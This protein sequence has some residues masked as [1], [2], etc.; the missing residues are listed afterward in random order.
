MGK[1][2]YQILGVDK[3][4]TQDEIKKAFRK[5]AHQHHPDKGG[6][7]AKF[8]EINEAYQVLN[9][10]KKR[11]QYDQF[12]TTFDGAGQQYSNMNWDDF[13]GQFGDIF[14]GFGFGGGQGQSRVHVDMGDIF[15]QAFGGGQSHARTRRDTR[16]HDMELRMDIDFKEAVFGTEKTI[17]LNIKETCQQCNGKGA[18]PDS[19]MITC[20]E[21][22]GSGQTVHTQRT[23]LGTFQQS[24]I[25]PTCHGE[26]TKPEQF[27]KKCH[28]DGRAEEKKTITIKVPAGIDH[29]QTIKLTG[30][31]EAGRRGGGAGDLYI[32][33]A[34]EN[35]TQFERDGYTI[36]T[37][38]VIPY[39]TAALGGTVRVETLDGKVDLKIPSGTQ[40]A[41]EFKLKNKGIPNLG[42]EHKRGDHYVHIAI[43]VPKKL[44]RKQK[45]LL[46]ELAEDNE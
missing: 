43:E 40:V 23:I 4:S 37:T 11:Q 17:S 10:E 35:N 38:K 12:G 7:E 42:N 46:E 21:C 39:T 27:C 41:Q 32:T 24:A 28:G 44:S 6:D 45:K 19:K 26:G 34:V 33:F 14:G 2:Y 3:S 29:G 25:C 31:G 8:K 9:D 13:M 1:D 18:E 15:S 30:K 22:Q 16:G 20:P 5:L 36:H